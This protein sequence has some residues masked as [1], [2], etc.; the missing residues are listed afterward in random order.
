[1]PFVV[2]PLSSLTT[3]FAACFM[4]VMRTLD[5][6]VV[7]VWF[8]VIVV[9][10]MCLRCTPLC[11]FWSAGV[12]CSFDV[13]SLHI[14][15]R[16]VVCPSVLFCCLCFKSCNR[17][18]LFLM[19]LIHSPRCRCCVCFVLI[20]MSGGPRCSNSLVLNALQLFCV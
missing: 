13:L 17:W 9:L 16:V 2:C 15:C 20:C 1:M 10:H 3:T 14:D 4:F 6:S 8:L 12:L 18:Q 7:G 5:S 11:V 19:C